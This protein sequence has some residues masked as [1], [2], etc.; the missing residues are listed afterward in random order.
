MSVQNQRAFL[1]QQLMREENC[2]SM[3]TRFAGIAGD[4][5]L[6]SLF[7]EFSH[8]AQAHSDALRSL[9]QGQGVNEDGVLQNRAT[10][11]AIPGDRPAPADAP[12]VGVP[13]VRGRDEDMIDDSFLSMKSMSDAYRS[14]LRQVSDE[15][16]AAA[17][18]GMR[19]DEDRQKEQLARY[20]HGRG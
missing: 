8:Q 1:E 14:A 15:N 19:Q 13:P 16:I 18:I 9:L 2:I 17:L 11:E 12:Q 5:G 20:L 4:P 6:R 7:T 3:Y 10:Q